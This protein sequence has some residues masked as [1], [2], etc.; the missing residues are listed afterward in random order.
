MITETK[1]ISTFSVS[2][3]RKKFPILETKING[4]PLVYFDNG[5]SSQKPIEVIEVIS[6][7][8]KHEHS[9]IHRGVH[10]LSAA[11]TEKYE[12][13][14][15][16]VAKFL[17]A[18]SQRE[19]IFTKGT[20]DSINLVAY[21]FGKAFLKK[22]DEIL[23]SAME[24]HSNIVPWQMV[25]EDK[26]A[27]LKV[28]PIN[29]SGEII[30]EEYLKLLNPKVKLVSVTHVSNALGT[31]NPVKRIIEE[32]HKMGI[33][34]LI[35][36]AQ[37]VP[38]MAI[39]VQELDCDFYAFSSH[40]MYGPTG[41]GVL[42]GKEKWLEKMPPYQ[43]GGDMISSVSFEKTTYNEIPLKF[44]AGTPHIA[45]VIGLSAA[46][47]FML[48]VGIQNIATHEYFLLDYATSKMKEVGGVKFIGESKE[49]AG[50]ISF[51]LN[52]HHPYDVGSLLDQMGVAVRTGHHC[53][54]PVMKRYQI[55]GTV[56][57]SFAV[58]NT[59]QEIDWFIESLVKTKKLLG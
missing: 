31:I 2:E 10:H 32:A 42:Y 9:N 26:E 57:A 58:Y 49:K 50:V 24:H 46:V 29:D 51:L 55:P 20:T 52:N 18:P 3:I 44:E 22:G 48:S 34:V 11:A 47:D 25:C 30:F 8:Y 19:I 15:I 43:G 12:T 35:D 36:G 56:R 7:Y 1:S 16:N 4:Y 14:R 13:S 45:G 41:V 40:K 5:A 28:I 38:H 33:P 23:V 37:A 17:N 59:T 39:D 27:S 21:S 6:N 53:A 54:E